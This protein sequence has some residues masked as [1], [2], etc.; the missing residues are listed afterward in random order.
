MNT[1]DP[2][3]PP[4]SSKSVATRDSAAPAHNSQAWDDHRIE[5]VIGT[6]LRVGVLL[7]AAVVILGGIIYLVRHGHTIVNYRNFEGSQSPLRKL[8]GIF[9][10]L[11]QPSGRAIIQFGLLLLIATPVARVLFSAIAFAR[12]RDHLYVALTLAVLAILTYSLF[13]SAL[14]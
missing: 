1:S 2:V 6:L 4:R 5:V 3:N 11:A 9:H 12:Q 14:H 8:S 13:G 7:S 10:G